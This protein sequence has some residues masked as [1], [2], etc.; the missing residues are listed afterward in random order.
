M[1]NLYDMMK[2]T[3]EKSAIKLNSLIGFRVFSRVI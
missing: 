2:Y 3:I 1:L